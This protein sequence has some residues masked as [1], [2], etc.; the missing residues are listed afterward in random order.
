MEKIKQERFA[1][2]LLKGLTVDEVSELTD[3]IKEERLE[4]HKQ[5]VKKL[6]LTDVSNQRELLI[7]FLDK[8]KDIR[9]DDV[10]SEETEDTV[11]KYLS[12]L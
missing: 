7:A 10:W 2:L 4:W 12:N 3:L 11:N 9:A 5:E 6:M 1:V 8:I